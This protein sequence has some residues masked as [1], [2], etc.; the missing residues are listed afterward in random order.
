MRYEEPHSSYLFFGFP[1][2]LK[3]FEFV[4]GASAFAAVGTAST[5]AV[6]FAYEAQEEAAAK[7]E[8]GKGHQDQD[9]EQLP[10]HTNPIIRPMTTVPHANSHPNPNP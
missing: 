1:F 9:N 2:A 4:N 10:V 6:P 3:S 7:V 5:G 8:R